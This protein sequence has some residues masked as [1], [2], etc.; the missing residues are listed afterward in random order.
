M[1]EDYLVDW[2]ILD[3]SKDTGQPTRRKICLL[4]VLEQF[5]NTLAFYGRPNLEF[6]N[7]H[8]GEAD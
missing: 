8:A 7:E 4:V 3:A 1:P 5:K 6:K 2:F